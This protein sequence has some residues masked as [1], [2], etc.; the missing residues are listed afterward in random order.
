MQGGYKVV[1]T[2]AVLVIDW[3]PALQQGG[4]RRGIERVFDRN[5]EQRF[6]LVEQEASIAVCTV[7]ER[8]ACLGGHRQHALL[9]GF[10]AVEQGRKCGFVEPVQD[11]DLRSRQQSRIKFERRVFGGGTDQCHYAAFDKWQKPV[12]LRAVET[13]D[14][15]N[16]Q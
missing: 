13:V 11:H 3:H 8:S 5:G 7:H 16:E 6:G 10:G 4:H 14:F 2:L 12:L 15:V 9:D 1:V